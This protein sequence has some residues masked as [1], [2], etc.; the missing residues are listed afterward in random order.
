[1]YRKQ[2]WT[3]GGHYSWIMERIPSLWFWTE[4]H[5]AFFVSY[6]IATGNA[7][8]APTWRV[9]K[10]TKK[11]TLWAQTAVSLFF[12]IAVVVNTVEH[13]VKSQVLLACL[14]NWNNRGRFGMWAQ[15]LELFYYYAQERN[16]FKVVNV[17]RI[18]CYRPKLG[19]FLPWHLCNAIWSDIRLEYIMFL[20]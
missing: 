16:T 2:K 19:G 9:K 14:F 13:Y 7:F 8:C 20:L 12:F 1:M 3:E 17:V 11:P 5:L 18:L 10:K 15:I 4:I 6:G